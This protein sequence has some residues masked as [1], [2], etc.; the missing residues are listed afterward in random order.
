M[1]YLFFPHAC[2]LK[3]HAFSC[4]FGNIPTVSYHLGLGYELQN[5]C[6]DKQ[7]SL[8][9]LALCSLSDSILNHPH[10]QPFCDIA[11]W[12]SIDFAGWIG[13]KSPRFKEWLFSN[14]ID[15]WKLLYFWSPNQTKGV[16]QA[17]CGLNQGLP[18]WFCLKTSGNLKNY[19]VYHHCPSFSP[20]YLQFG[21]KSSHFQ[22]HTH[23]SRESLLHPIVPQLYP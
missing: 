2:L 20:V 23:S 21:T 1:F 11:W 7:R 5:Q 9:E 17:W 6:M 16:I 3:T 12:P 15:L 14:T 22:S 4:W 13:W 8:N 18:I 10:L 19:M